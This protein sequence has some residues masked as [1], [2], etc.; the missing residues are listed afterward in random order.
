MIEHKCTY[1]EQFKSALA[2]ETKAQAEQWMEREI[3]HYVQHHGTNVSEALRII[4]SNLGYMAGYYNTETA[5]KI[6][7]LFNA[8]HPVF[9][10]STYHNDVTPEQAFEL[11]EKPAKE[12]S[13]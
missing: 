10:T 4:K 9:G 5:K 11:G 8:V 7:E 2:C 12:Q 6:H 3:Q 1:G 13:R